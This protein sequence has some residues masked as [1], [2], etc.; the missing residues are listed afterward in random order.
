LL[1]ADGGKFGA[2]QCPGE[3]DQQQRAVVQADQVGLDRR[4]DLAQDRGGVRPW[5]RRRGL[6]ERS[7]NGRNRVPASLQ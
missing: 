3:A 1:E 6:G 7:G 4:P 5:F 2:A